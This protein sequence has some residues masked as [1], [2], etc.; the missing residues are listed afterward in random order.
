MGI[1]IDDDDIFDN[2][3][4]ILGKVPYRVTIDVIFE[5]DAKIKEVIRGL[6]NEIFDSFD[7]KL[8]VNYF[9]FELQTLTLKKVDGYYT[10]E[11][12]EVKVLTKPQIVLA[13]EA[14]EELPEVLGSLGCVYTDHGIEI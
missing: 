9:G 13:Y 11:S 8:V 5:Q 6:C 12:D 4:S 10:W 2:L 1:E 3:S 7:N 14:L